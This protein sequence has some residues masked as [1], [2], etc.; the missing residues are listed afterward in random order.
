M[1]ESRIFAVTSVEAQSNEKKKPTGGVR[2]RNIEE[3]AEEI[4]SL[5]KGGLLRGLELV[6]LPTQEVPDHSLH[7]GFIVW[8]EFPDEPENGP[9]E[10]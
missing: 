1:P 4:A 5:C 8:A 10:T 9:Q 7:P 2:R 6:D 3:V